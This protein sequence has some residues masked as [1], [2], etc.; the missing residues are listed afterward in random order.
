MDYF[1][2][3]KREIIK[4]PMNAS[5]TSRGIEPLYNVSEN[6]KIVIVGQAPGRIAEETRLYWNDLSGDRLRDW[7]GVSREMFYESDMIAQMPMDFYFPGK[8][9]SGDAPP[10]KGF[11]EKWHPLLL[12]GMTEVKTI[13]LVGAYAQKYYLGERGKKNLTE[14]V[15]SFKD[16]L[17][18]YFPLVH[19]SPLNLGWMKKNPWFLEEVIPV[20]KQF[21][22]ESIVS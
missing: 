13:I 22:K 19:P 9:R 8:G 11:A 4:D 1:E 5:Y 18:E 2:E 6:A 7:M 20:L 3:I 10:R 21:I 12:R 16:Y 17:P 15:K 14:T